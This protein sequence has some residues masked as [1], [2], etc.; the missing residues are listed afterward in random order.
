MFSASLRS[1]E[2]MMVRVAHFALADV[3]P[4]PALQVCTVVARP[5]FIAG[6]LHL[7]HASQIDQWNAS[8]FGRACLS[9]ATMRLAGAR[10][11]FSKGC[12]FWSSL[13]TS[14]LLADFATPAMCT[15]AAML[16]WRHPSFPPHDAVLSEVEAFQREHRRLP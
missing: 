8:A 11:H 2:M 3:L 15:V 4:G 12:R 6:C 5:A 9:A 13:I 7:W 1:V 14:A 10:V 16:A